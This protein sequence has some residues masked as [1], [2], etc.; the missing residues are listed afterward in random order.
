MNRRG[1]PNLYGS[2]RVLSEA[3]AGSCAVPGGV[4]LLR[5]K[6]FGHPDRP[7]GPGHGRTT[8]ASCRDNGCDLQTGQR[9]G[10]RCATMARLT[11]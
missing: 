1:R 9:R 7:S 4:R 5:G 2:G 11:S 10:E 8:G 3:H 6:R